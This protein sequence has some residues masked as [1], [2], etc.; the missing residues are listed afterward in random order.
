MTE[1]TARHGLRLRQR[2][3]LADLGTVALRESD[4]DGL[5]QEACR[6]VAEGL[7]VR[8]CKVLEIMNHG[9][10]LLVRAWVGWH[11][12]VVGEAILGGDDG[13][14]A[15]HA[16]RTGQPVISND[17]AKEPRFRTPQLLV[18]HGVR[19]VMNVVI[20]GNGEPFGVLEA[21]SPDPGSFSDGDI[22]FMQAAANLLGLATER[23]RRDAA[24]RQE[25]EKRDL[26]LR[27]ADHRIK[28][29]LQL[30]AGLLTLQR[31]RLKYPLAKEA[32]DEAIARVMTVAET[33]RQLHQSPDLRTIPLHKMLADLCAHVGRLSQA[34]TVDCAQEEV[35]LDAE[36]AIPLGL[37]VTELLTN[38]LRHA[39]A[40][41]Q[42]GVVRLRMSLAESQLEVVI[43][44]QG[45]GITDRSAAEREGL[46]TTIVNRLV[47]QIGAELRTSSQ[48]GTGTQVTLRLPLQPESQG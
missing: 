3:L 27:E 24:L 36:R 29:S 48:T 41:G 20:R 23:A 46:G 39:Y 2:E 18:E 21:D 42:S 16:L 8:F 13:S 32:R 34:V 26:L 43:S 45:V 11:E 4:F 44:D 33:H 17:L 47:H 9:N 35:H 7:G 30:I 10:R 1:E 25:V 31:S 28:N 14:P 40:P 6:L 37:V 12:G 15:G 22:S 38:A 19:R 5:L